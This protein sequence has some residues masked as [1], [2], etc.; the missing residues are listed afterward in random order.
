MATGRAVNFALYYAGW[1]AAILGPAWG[2]PWTGTLIA[3]ALIGCHLALARRPGNELTLMV[4]AAAVGTVVDSIQIA[5]GLLVFPSA[6][7]LGF[8]P[9]AWLV[10]LWAQFA[11]TFHFSMQWLKGRPWLA[12]L[13]GAVGGPLA[14]LAGRKLGVVEFHPDV[15]PSLLSL[16]VVWSAV[17]P[18]LLGLAARQRGDGIGE[19]RRWR[20]VAER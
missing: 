19:Y 11:A 4:A 6:G 8:L 9:P 16:A 13:F 18:L 10:V 20:R 3:L 7:R 17:L 5:A 12:A 1:F 15:W 2:Y 14:F